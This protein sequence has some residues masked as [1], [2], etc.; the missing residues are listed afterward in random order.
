MDD[1]IIFIQFKNL[2]R[3]HDQPEVIVVF[4]YWKLFVLLMKQN[5]LS[6]GKEA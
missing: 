4:K 3:D 6:F 2:M 1:F 5:I